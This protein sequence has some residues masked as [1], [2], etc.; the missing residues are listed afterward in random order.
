M[1][2]FVGSEPLKPSLEEAQIGRLVGHFKASRV[3]AGIVHGLD[4]LRHDVHMG[5]RIDAAWDGQPRELEGRM[6]IF[7][8]LGI[9]PS[10]DDASFHTPHTRVQVQLCGQ[11]LRRELLLRDVG[12]KRLSTEKDAVTAN[13]AHDGD[14]PIDQQ[15]AQVEHLAH[16][17]AYGSSCSRC[18]MKKAFS[19]IRVASR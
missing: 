16:A 11:R 7:A 9:P 6:A 4:R 8:C 3:F 13:R 18:W 5:L 14:A 19:D 2:R 15:L 1:C 17:S 10:A 12:T